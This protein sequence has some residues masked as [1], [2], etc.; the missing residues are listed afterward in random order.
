M[1]SHFLVLPFRID[2]TWQEINTRKDIDKKKLIST[3]LITTF[4]LYLVFSLFFSLRFKPSLTTGYPLFGY[5]FIPITQVISDL[6]LVLVLFLYI[7]TFDEKKPFFS[8]LVLVILSK[9]PT[10][11]LSFLLNRIST[12]LFF[13]PA[14]LWQLLIISRGMRIRFSIARKET[15]SI[16]IAV[17]IIYAFIIYAT[18]I[19]FSRLILII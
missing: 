6:I 18:K 14:F 1:I 12:E 19:G 15:V 10:A 2:R 16:M 5:L 8:T 11:S 7:R 17:Y 3:Y 4:P 9:F 13:L